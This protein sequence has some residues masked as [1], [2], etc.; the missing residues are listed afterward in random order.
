MRSVHHVRTV[1]LHVRTLRTRRAAG[2]ASLGTRKNSARGSSNKYFSTAAAVKVLDVHH[3]RRIVPHK[4]KIY[5]NEKTLLPRIF[6]IRTCTYMS[7]CVCVCVCVNYVR[8]GYVPCTYTY[9]KFG[10][11]SQDFGVAKMPGVDSH[12][13]DAP[14]GIER[15]VS[16]SRSRP[17]WTPWAR[18]LAV[19]KRYSNIC[20]PNRPAIYNRGIY[21]ACIRRRERTFLGETR[22]GE[23]E[24]ERKRRGRTRSTPVVRRS[25][26]T[27]RSRSRVA[28]GSSQGEGGQ[29]V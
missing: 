19:E 23:Q 27:R 3:V 13:R 22:R 28:V 10:E 8:H 14:A 24:R 18:F 16:L 2:T 20:C 11:R 12:R 1:S 4:R 29:E 9:E 17:V 15:V 6:D 25:I 7:E 21:T 5:S 26:S